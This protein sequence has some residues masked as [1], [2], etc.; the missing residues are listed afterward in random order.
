MVLAQPK[1]HQRAGGYGP[2]RCSSWPSCS[3]ATGARS[4]RLQ[5]GAPAQLQVSTCCA[6]SVSSTTG[7]RLWERADR[8]DVRG[9]PRPRSSNGSVGARTR[10]C[11]G[12][13]NAVTGKPVLSTKYASRTINQTPLTKAQPTV[14]E[15]L[16]DAA[17]QAGQW[18]YSLPYIRARADLQPEDAPRVPRKA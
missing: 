7:R 11:P 18:R 4:V 9:C 14:V 3:F 13:V 2:R 17:T 10:R 12:S 1:G 5:S 15:V 8:I 6:G 16:A